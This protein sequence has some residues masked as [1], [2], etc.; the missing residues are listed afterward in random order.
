MHAQGLRPK[1]GLLGLLPRHAVFHARLIIHDIA[2]VPL[3]HG[4]FAVKW[5]FHNAHAPATSSASTN[6]STPSLTPLPSPA[7]PSPTSS[8]DASRSDL[9]L[10][11]HDYSPSESEHHL[12]PP[13]RAHSHPHSHS[14]SGSDTDTDSSPSPTTSRTPINAHSYSYYSYGQYLTPDA[15]PPARSPIPPL[16]APTDFSTAA[17]GITAYRPLD[18]HR[19]SWSHRV[20]AAVQMSVNRDTAELLPCRLKLVVRQSE[21]DSSTPRLGVVEL[22]LAEYV[23]AGSVT[24]RYLLKES[25]VNAT[26]RVTIELEKIGGVDQFVA[27]PLRKAQVMA[28]VGGLISNER[29][30]ARSPFPHE[31]RRHSPRPS[32]SSISLSLSTRPLSISPSPSSASPSSAMTLTGLSPHASLPTP[33]TE[34]LIEALFNPFPS[35]TATPFTYVPAPPSMST[36][37][38]GSTLGGRTL[39]PAASER[40]MSDSGH[41]DLDGMTLER[42]GSYMSNGSTGGGKGDDAC[43][44]RSQARS[45]STKSSGGASGIGGKLWKKLG[46]GGGSRPSTPGHG[47]LGSPGRMAAGR[48]FSARTVS[49]VESH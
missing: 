35:T 41:L 28:G 14:E 1:K 24:R 27:P 21:D 49:T 18:A 37:V 15:P 29:I 2:D 19:A 11:T 32:S 25:K 16:P 33:N 22:N 26:L 46:G 39:A 17:R 34:A 31:R 43:S 8:D 4:N 20:D 48:A 9:D 45:T 6:A 13:S 38:S 30:R 7:L 42:S 47:A 44:V 10:P 36:S 12:R 23:G 40:S 3:I 5:R